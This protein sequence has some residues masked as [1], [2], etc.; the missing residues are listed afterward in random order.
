MF[1][2]DVISICNINLNKNSYL[3]ME[4]E[5]INVTNG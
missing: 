5:E 3:Y 2:I 4:K 1:G